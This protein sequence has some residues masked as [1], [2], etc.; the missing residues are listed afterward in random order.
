MRHYLTLAALAVTA[1]AGCGGG[2]SYGGGTVTSTGNGTPA[3]GTTAAGFVITIAGLRFSP[4]NLAVPPGTTVT[5]INDDSML[6]S[7][8]S[9]ATAGSFTKGSV[10]GV[11]FDTGEFTGQRTFTIPATATAGTVIPYYCVVHT[12]TMATPNGTIT[13][14]PNAG[15]SSVP[16]PATGPSAY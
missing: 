5:V 15:S 3:G 8:T 4:V 10:A 6:H 12:S 11:S 2:S 7:V 1:A 13:I 14:D 9:E 16:A